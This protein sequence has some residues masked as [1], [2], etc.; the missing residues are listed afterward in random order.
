MLKTIKRKAK[1]LLLFIALAVLLCALGAL[2]FWLYRH[3]SSAAFE[4]ATGLLMS[5]P[6]IAWWGCVEIGRKSQGGEA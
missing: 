4:L 6:Y 3:G 1:T 2:I 5:L